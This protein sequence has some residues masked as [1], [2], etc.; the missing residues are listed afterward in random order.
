M[1]S[2][3][4][5]NF[6]GIF[7]I[8][9]NQATPV[10][11]LNFMEQEVPEKF[12]K[13]IYSPSASIESIADAIQ[14][15]IKVPIYHKKYL[16][17]DL[18]SLELVE[19]LMD[20]LDLTDNIDIEPH[21]S[22]HILIIKVLY[23]FPTLLKKKEPVLVLRKM[24]EYID[25]PSRDPK[26]LKWAFKIINSTTAADGCANF[27]PLLREK[28]GIV[29]KIV[30][31]FD[32][33]FLASPACLFV[34]NMMSDNDDLPLL[35]LSE[36][37][38]LDKIT[39]IIRNSDNKKLVCDICFDVSNITSGAMKH[40][41]MVVYHDVFSELIALAKSGRTET[42]KEAGS[43]VANT[44]KHPG[45]PLIKKLME[46]G[47][48]ELLC[49]LMACVELEM[50]DLCLHALYLLVTNIEGEVDGET[51]IYNPV[52][53]RIGECGGI[54]TIKE[55]SE[56]CEDPIS[57]EFYKIL[58]EVHLGTR[59]EEYLARKRG[60]KLKRAA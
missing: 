46:L 55:G 58:M 6:L 4:L 51:V 60:L 56:N 3:P 21:K 50:Y 22:C 44:T 49:E 18:F 15:L 17:M 53:I 57:E 31:F 5:I 28:F 7:S 59:Y 11:L 26:L 36:T 20:L 14:G 35:I 33:P 41:E 1:K 45:V 12:I 37:D 39:A 2:F 23:K 19:R 54:E 30:S 47:I 43:A 25:Q 38:Y 40:I 13:T 32:I 42:R 24:L 48:V 34:G 8:Q 29:K 10:N 27:V 9:F 52:A 16:A